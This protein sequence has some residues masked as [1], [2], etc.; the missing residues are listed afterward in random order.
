MKVVELFD[1]DEMRYELGST[2]YSMSF[3]GNHQNAPRFLSGA[4]PIVSEH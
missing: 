4:N 1:A 2:P 3:L